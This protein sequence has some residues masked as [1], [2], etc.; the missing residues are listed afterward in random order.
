VLIVHL[1][2][3]QIGNTFQTVASR[4]PSRASPDLHFACT[5]KQVYD[6]SDLARERAFLD[7]HALLIL[8]DSD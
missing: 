5:R 2:H 8:E 4:E 6:P 1:P 3:A 7:S